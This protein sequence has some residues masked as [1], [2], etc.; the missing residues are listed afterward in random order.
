MQE[1]RKA[2]LPDYPALE[3]LFAT[4]IGGAEW[5]PPAA[6][7]QTDFVA[8]TAGETVIVCCTP[9]GELKGVVT[10]FEPESFIHFLIVAPAFHRQG[11][12]RALLASLEAW[13]PFPHRLKCVAANTEAL[14]FY[15]ALGWTRSGRGVSDHGPFILLE[16]SRP[17]GIS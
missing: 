15:A 11:V 16:R 8:A 13:L 12:G 9:E 1:I 4:T 14:A 3:E 10:V 17:A 2:R 6:R 5:L 7:T